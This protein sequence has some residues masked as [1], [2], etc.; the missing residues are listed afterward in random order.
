MGKNIKDK[1]KGKI[2]RELHKILAKKRKPKKFKY[3]HVLIPF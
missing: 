3:V 2:K 1:L